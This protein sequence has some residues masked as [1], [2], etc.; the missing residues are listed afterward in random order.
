MGGRRLGLTVDESGSYWEA[1]KTCQS[2][3]K[4]TMP[5]NGFRT[6]KPDDK[7]LWRQPRRDLI[8]TD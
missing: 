8:E 3:D 4:L 7:K 5:E 1:A 6:R 2:D